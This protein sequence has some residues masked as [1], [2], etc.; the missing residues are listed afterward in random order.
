VRARI[1]GT[2]VI[3][4]CLNMAI[5]KARVSITIDGA[6]AISVQSEGSSHLNKEYAIPDPTIMIA[7]C[8]KLRGQI[9]GS[10]FSICTGILYC[11]EIR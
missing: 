2:K 11:I 9:I 1:N 5:A 4:E 7:S 10:S 3:S 8:L 6:A